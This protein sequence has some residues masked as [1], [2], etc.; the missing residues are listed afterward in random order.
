MSEELLVELLV[1][2]VAG[3]RYGADASSVLRIDRMGPEGGVGAPL[4]APLKGGRALVFADATGAERRLQVDAIEGVRTVS[5]L[6]LRRLPQVAIATPISIGA[7]L[8]GARAVLLVDLQRM[9]SA[10]SQH[11]VLQTRE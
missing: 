5:Q 8:D 1:F 10:A 11:D 4:G 2:E 9:A 7:W 6:E 3:A